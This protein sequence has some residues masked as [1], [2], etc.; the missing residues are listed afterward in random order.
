MPLF[1]TRKLDSHNVSNNFPFLF[2]LPLVSTNTHTHTDEWTYFEHG[3][4]YREHE[5]LLRW[6]QMLP[7]QP[8]LHIFNVGKNEKNGQDV[9]LVEYYARYGFNAFYMRTGFF[10]GG[11]DYETE[12]KEKEID[13]FSWGFMGDGYHN[14]T[15][16]GELEEDESR[17]D[18]L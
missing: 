2:L 9:K 5:S 7:K 13:R 1:L 17:R 11:H 18:S 15:R 12:K 8:P 4:A 6:I 10:N 16:Y 3:G 14:T